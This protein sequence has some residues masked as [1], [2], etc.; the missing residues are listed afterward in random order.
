MRVGLSL[1]LNRLGGFGGSEGPSA[2]LW[3]PAEIATALWLDASDTDSITDSLGA[4]T[5]WNDLSGNLNHASQGSASYRF[6]TG[7][8]TLNGLNGMDCSADYMD[9]PEISANNKSIYAVIAPDTDTA[10]QVIV[11]NNGNTKNRQMRLENTTRYVQI[12]GAT[13]Y[14]STTDSNPE[15]VTLSVANVI[16][17][18][19]TTTLQFTVNGTL[20]DTLD[21]QGAG[22]FDVLRVG[23]FESSASFPFDG[24]LGE[25][26]ITNTVLSTADRQRMEGY[27][28]HKWGAE[29]LLPG[30]HPYKSAAPTV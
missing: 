15:A 27:M 16:G 5:D 3:T 28:A 4:V 23:A 11:G 29:G 2:G 20:V 6:T 22:D 30:G 24:I 12:A 21:S 17:M 8:R 1:G 26:V 10:L 19:P 14:T 18:I 7:T 9:F 13:P 25:V